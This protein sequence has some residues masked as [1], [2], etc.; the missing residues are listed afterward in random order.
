M[1]LKSFKSAYDFHIQNKVI[2]Y[3]GL[4]SGLMFYAVSSDDEVKQGLKLMSE[5]YHNTVPNKILLEFLEI[6]LG[7]VT[8][9]EVT[10]KDVERIIAMSDK[11]D[12]AKDVDEETKQ[13]LITLS[14]FIK[15]NYLKRV[16]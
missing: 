6:I 9:E 14:S 4:I 11:I 8:G 13:E 15:Y 2:C 7:T 10:A 3:E 12:A 1:S 5:V 16:T